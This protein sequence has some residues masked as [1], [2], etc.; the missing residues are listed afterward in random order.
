VRV[1]SSEEPRTSPY[2]PLAVLREVAMACTATPTRELRDRAAA[3]RHA[4]SF[5]KADPEL[6][7]AAVIW[8]PEEVLAAQGD[9]RSS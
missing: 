5:D 4:V 2:P 1:A 9:A 6:T 7:L 3:G 8:P